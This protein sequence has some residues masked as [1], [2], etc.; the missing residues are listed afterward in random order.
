MRNPLDI[1]NGKVSLT[2]QLD[3]GIY[4]CLKDASALNGQTP[5]EF[6][7]DVTRSE[8]KALIESLAQNGSTKRL[9]RKSTG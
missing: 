4:N 8:V 7:A 3:K 6:I 5:S 1:L 2:V 9:S